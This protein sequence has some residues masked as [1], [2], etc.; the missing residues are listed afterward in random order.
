MMIKQVNSPIFK[1]HTLHT[2]IIEMSKCGPLNLTQHREI[3]WDNLHYSDEPYQ[4]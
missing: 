3:S 1:L 4:A 2:Y